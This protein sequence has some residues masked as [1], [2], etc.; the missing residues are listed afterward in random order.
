M[1]FE[2]GDIVVWDD[3]C[4]GYIH[5]IGRHKCM[6]LGKSAPDD[7]RRYFV[8]F[9]CDNFQTWILEDDLFLLDEWYYRTDFYGK[10]LDRIG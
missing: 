6:V 2:T 7:V 10:I 4:E 8:Q 1:K 5:N 9:F 3:G